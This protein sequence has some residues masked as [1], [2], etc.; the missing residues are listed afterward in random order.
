MSEIAA[1]LDIQPSSAAF[2]LKMLED[3]DLL[4]VEYSTKRKG[5]L[6]YYSYNIRDI[7]FRMRPLEGVKDS[8]E[9]FVASISV[10]DYVDADF[11][12]TFGLA[13][14]KKLLFFNDKKKTFAHERHDAQIIWNSHYGRLTYALENSFAEKA[15]L[16]SVS[17]SMELCSEAK[18]Y[19]HDFPSDITF[20]INGVELCTWTSPGDFGDKYGIF[21]PA[22]WF[23]E[24]TKY[25]LMTTVTVRK[26]G[27][28]L[29]DKLVNRSI[30]LQNIKVS[31]GD[32]LTF[33]FGVKKDAV[34][35]GG[36]NIFG[37]KFG[38]YNT[39]ITFTATFK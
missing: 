33:S 8:L 27:V 25:G 35:L 39:A 3:N 14:D 16:K 36:F 13:S 9:P 10:G 37:E 32:R 31:D 17:F 2:H 26:T 22:W 21:T 38:D 7:L 19:N 18:G 6:K 29:N 5:T 12:E 30:T 15:P 20:W 24:S 28:F 23:P 11:N 34:H 1:E 4:T